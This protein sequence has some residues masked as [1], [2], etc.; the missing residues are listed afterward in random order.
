MATRII[1]F[2]QAE[3]DELEKNLD[4]LVL[5]HENSKLLV[6]VGDFIV[7]GDDEYKVV[8]WRRPHKVGSTGRVY[9]HHNGSTQVQEYFPSVCGLKWV[10]PN[11]A[12][13]M[14]EQ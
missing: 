8:T 11:E 3:Y 14:E 13:D 9:V 1:T 4:K 12:R 2:D 5:V 6:K 7:S 10:M